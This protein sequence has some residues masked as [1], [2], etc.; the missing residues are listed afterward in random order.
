MRLRSACGRPF[1]KHGEGVIETGRIGPI[2][3]SFPAATGHI[4]PRAGPRRVRAREGREPNFHPSVR[5]LS[6]G[7]PT[8]FGKAEACRLPRPTLLGRETRDVIPRKG[9]TYRVA[10]AFFVAA[11]MSPVAL[12]ARAHHLPRDIT[13]EVRLLAVE[14]FFCHHY[15]SQHPPPQLAPKLTERSAEET[16]PA[17]S[18]PHKVT[19]SSQTPN[20]VS[21]ELE[22]AFRHFSFPN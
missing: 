21:T 3:A 9:S 11:L 13:A 4:D 6:S 15:V 7:R 22:S 18:A 12:L 5:P 2:Y 19:S 14:S 8:T 1:Y 20:P 17:R 16:R 10:W